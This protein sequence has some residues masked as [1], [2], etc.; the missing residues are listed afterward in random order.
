MTE[1][2]S[3]AKDLEQ[4]YHM[5]LYKRYPLTLVRGEGTRV[6]D[7]DGKEYLDALA[8]IAVNN[9]GHCHPT[10]VE[11]IRSQATKLMHISNF[12][13]NE[14]QSRLAQLLCE[15]SGMDRA[16]FCNSGVEAVEAAIKLARK[17]AASKK[18]QGSVV[19]ME[20]CFHGRTLATIT[21]GSEKY[22]KG[23]EPLPPGFDVIPMNDL[24][25]LDKVL[26]D[27]PIAFILEVVQGEGGI[28][29]VGHEYLVKLRRVCT[30]RNILLIV[31]EVQSGMGRT[32]KMFAF[33]DHEI[34]PDIMTVAKALGNGFPIGSMLATQDV[35]ESFDP[36]NHGTTFGGNPLACAAACAVLETMTEENIVEQSASKGDYLMG[37]L[38]EATK[39][40]KAVKEIRGRGLMIG[41]ELEFEGAEV[42]TR[43]MDKGVLANCTADTVVRL[44]PPLIISEQELDR[45]VETLVTSIEEVEKGTNV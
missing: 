41:I 9:L 16:F 35:A 22:R 20:N 32:G 1:K 13:F 26:S 7:S 25:A 23:F 5:Q 21:M 43:M 2:S 30:D 6:W 27:D 33:Q 45:V 17:Y 29:P 15:A 42:V 36:G 12:Y 44:T 18:K 40:W 11:A 14:P 24:D 34:R 3:I 19:A 4:K 10:V 39:G 8:G 28:N 31:D 37:K 38:R